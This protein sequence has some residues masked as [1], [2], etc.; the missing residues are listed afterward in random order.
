MKDPKSIFINSV[1]K[2]NKLE[3][4]YNTPL[5]GVAFSSKQGYVLELNQQYADMLGYTRRELVGTFWTDF[6]PPEY[7]EL[8][9]NLYHRL[10]KKEISCFTYE[11]EYI[12]KDK[13]RIWVE[14]SVQ[15]KK[16][17]FDNIEYFIVLARDI[18]D[19]KKTLLK[20][21]AEMKQNEAL[22]SKLKF[23]NEQLKEFANL[24][25]HNLRAP[26]GSMIGLLELYDS[27]IVDYKQSI[28]VF[29]EQYRNL[30]Y[31]LL[32]T[33]NTIGSALDIK[34][35]S[36]VKKEK[37]SF[38]EILNTVI[39]SLLGKAKDLDFDLITDF[40]LEEITYSKSYLI[41]II[42]NLLSNSL[43]YRSTERKLRV[44]IKTYYTNEQEI[45]EFSDNGTGINLE[46]NS[47]NIFGL[48]KT[49][50]T[51]KDSK[52]VGLFLTRKHVEAM[53]GKIFAESKQNYGIKFTLI[54]NYH[55]N[56]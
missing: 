42:Q 34:D 27:G 29:S 16:N 11:K 49:F 40:E 30:T 50:H 9:L 13:S 35:R 1:W 24:I 45:M 54:F 56:H 47:R 33:I 51:N 43:K 4:L 25:S 44:E 36:E 53:G 15:S 18:D 6:S 20:L 31:S 2:E 22:I 21:D 7:K 14:I 46:Q 28:G 32:D 19:R 17:E 37:V 52:G 3:A 23:Q 39:I 12:R 26:V 5:I 55:E 8:T 48:H 10:L 41:S 38:K